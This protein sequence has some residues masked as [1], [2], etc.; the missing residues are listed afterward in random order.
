MF[1]DLTVVQFSK[2]LNNLNNFLDKAAAHAEAKKYDVSVLLN[3]RLAP[4][5]FNLI[6]QVQIACDTAKLGVAR[7]TG[8]VELAPVHADTETT[9]PELKARIQAVLDYL[10]TF[11]PADFAETAERHISQPRWEGKYLTGYEFAIQHAIPNIY[12]HVT[13][14]YAILRHNGVD[15]GKKDYLGSLPYKS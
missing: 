4:D 7:L 10:A 3:S 9:L 15:L 8:K 2:I 5:Q 12:F 13:T 11:T 1:Y 14:A 6:R